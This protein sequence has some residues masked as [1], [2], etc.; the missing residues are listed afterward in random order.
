MSPASTTTGEAYG[1]AGVRLRERAL[2]MAP[3]TARQGYRA[4]VGQVADKARTILPT[5]VNGRIESAVKLVLQG[6]VE[7]LDDG[8][9]KVGSSDPTRYYHLI[10]QACTCT[11]F[12]QQKAPSGCCKHRV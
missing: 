12:T 1:H 7:L 11:D 5:A 6:D 8:T 4:L 10:G 2:T 9:I 3:A